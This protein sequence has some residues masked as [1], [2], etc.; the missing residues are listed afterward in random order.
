[1]FNPERITDVEFEKGYYMQISLESGK[2]I[3]VGIKNKLESARFQDLKRE[4]L[5]FNGKIE[6]LGRVVQWNEN[7][8]ITLDEIMYLADAEN[9]KEEKV[10]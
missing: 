8:E 7:T 6:L 1:M 9:R 3:R 4:E 10:R 2:T 5:F